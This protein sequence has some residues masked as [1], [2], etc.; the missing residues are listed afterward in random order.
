MAI[1]TMTV[2]L[3]TGSVLAASDMDVMD[4]EP[5]IDQAITNCHH[6]R[7]ENIDPDLLWDLAWIE[8]QYDIPKRLRG[9]LMAA[10]CSESGYN[11]EAKGDYR[12][13]RPKAIGL[14]QMWKWWEKK[15]GYAVDRRNPTQAAEAYIKHIAKQLKKVKRQCKHRTAEKQWIAAWVTAIRYPKPEGRCNEKP[16][17]LR[18]LRKWHRN[19]KKDS[20]KLKALLLQVQER[21]HKDGGWNKESK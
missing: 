14:F 2:V 8:S 3:L 13:G 12:K 20:R 19:I 10:A 15:T 17:H 4:Y 1:G 7:K 21:V 6:A 18:L 5:I 11:I 9:M 16:N